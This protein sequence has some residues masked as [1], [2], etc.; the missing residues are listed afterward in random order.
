MASA[1]R[2]AELQQA[3]LVARRRARGTR[4]SPGSKPASAITCAAI[5]WRRAPISTIGATAG[6][7]AA[8]AS[9]LRSCISGCERE[10]ARP[11]SALLLSALCSSALATVSA[12]TPA[13]VIRGRVEVRRAPPVRSSGG[14]NVSDL[15]MHAAH[16][17]PDQRRSVVYLE[18]APS[19][20]VPRYRAA[21]RDDGP[22]E[23]DVRAA[24]ARDHGRDDGRFSQQ[25][26]HLPQ[27]VF[28]ERPEPLRSGP[29][30]RRPI[31]VGPVR[32]SRAS[33]A[34]SARSTHT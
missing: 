30:R 2:S 1:P 34:C 3:A 12:Q 11:L 31:A 16:D 9:S 13:G 20:R 5:C 23:R 14:P 8:A 29:L 10:H 18:S 22:A 24:R 32:S 19:L 15:G 6:R 33:C 7:S 28:A 27:R 21:A 25:R 4:R 26:P 17:P